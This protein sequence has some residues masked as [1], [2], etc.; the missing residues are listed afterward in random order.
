MK[1]RVDLTA[2]EPRVD[3]LEEVIKTDFHIASSYQLGQTISNHVKFVT[4]CAK[5]CVDEYIK[6]LD[7]YSLSEIF[8]K[9]AMETFHGYMIGTKMKASELEATGDI[10]VKNERVI[11]ENTLVQDFLD[12]YPECTRQSELEWKQ[13]PF[14]SKDDY[15]YE[16][17][18]VVA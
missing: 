1:V 2:D 15:M 11:I 14:K 3:D 7:S 18:Q 13:L 6:F 9:H 10:L 4:K 17:Y 5:I 16:P 8:E 12:C